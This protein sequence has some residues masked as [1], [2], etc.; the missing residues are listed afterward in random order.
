METNL[1]GF[2]RLRLLAAFQVLTMPSGCFR[3]THKVA[4]QIILEL[5]GKKAHHTEHYKADFSLEQ[6]LEVHGSDAG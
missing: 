1:D 3:V 6:Y 4:K 5:T 2:D